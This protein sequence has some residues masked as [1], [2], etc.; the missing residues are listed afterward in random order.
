MAEEFEELLIL[1]IVRMIDLARYSYCVSCGM[2]PVARG[3]PKV[4]ALLQ[5]TA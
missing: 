5:P 4:L 1:A 2:C 3:I